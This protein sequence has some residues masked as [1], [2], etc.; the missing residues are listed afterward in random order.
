MSICSCQSPGIG[1]RSCAS[2]LLGAD[3]LAEVFGGFAEE[4]A[5]DPALS[6]AGKVE[7]AAYD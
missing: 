1:S 6:E 4:E 2:A 3:G 7:L 5:W